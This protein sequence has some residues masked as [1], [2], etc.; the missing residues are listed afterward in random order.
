MM[1]LER[2]KYGTFIM[3]NLPF[4]N[5]RKGI[6]LG[7]LEYLEKVESINDKEE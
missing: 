6:G 1:A 5:H 4:M 3:L 7:N 2:K